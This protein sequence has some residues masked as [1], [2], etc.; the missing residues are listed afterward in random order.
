MDFYID[1]VR[2]KRYCELSGESK[3]TVYHR[4]QR[5]EWLDGVHTQMRGGVLWCNLRKIE[6]W[7]AKGK[8]EQLTRV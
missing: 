7:V 8:I 4:R 5:G 1:W 2:L 3:R 6:E